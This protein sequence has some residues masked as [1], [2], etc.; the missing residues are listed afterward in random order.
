MPETA[1]LW[2]LVTDERIAIEAV[3]SAVDA[4]LAEL[5][6]RTHAIG[7]DHVLDLA[8]SVAAHAFASAAMVDA[9]ADEPARRMA[10]RSALLMARPIA[11]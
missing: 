3:G 9:E 2:D 4:Y 1:T 8:A 5:A 7:P 10:V 6:T 11:R